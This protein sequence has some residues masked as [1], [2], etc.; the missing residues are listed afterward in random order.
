M[1]KLKARGR[2]EIFRIEKIKEVPRQGFA[3]RYRV[4]KALMS[5]G[6]VLEKVDDGAWKIIGKVKPGLSAE[7]ALKIYADRGWRL[8]M[9]SPSYFNVSDDTVTGKSSEP[10]RTER[11]AERSKKN[12]EAGAERRK[13]QAE[14][15]ERRSGPG[16]YITNHSTS[17]LR[18]AAEIGPL[19]DMDTAV[20]AARKRAREFHSGR[21][22]YLL[23]VRIIESRSRWDAERNIGKVVWNSAQSSDD[24]E[25]PGFYIVPH[26][27][28][29]EAAGPYDTFEQAENAAWEYLRSRDDQKLQEECAAEWVQCPPVRIIESQNSTQALQGKGWVWWIDGQQ[30][31]PPVDPRQ[32][33]FANGF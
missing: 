11:E 15:E 18:L 30:K 8:L 31:G 22:N 28:L 9:A 26:R 2:Q 6:N 32:A 12:R 27:Y 7:A 29:D 19:A 14:E 16:L 17:S 5:D 10:L 13:R 25:E 4:Q 24:D 23:P 20:K 3:E 1:A 21:L 33:S